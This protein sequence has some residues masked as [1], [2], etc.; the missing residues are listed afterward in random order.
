M[1]YLKIHV[2]KQFHVAN[3][4]LQQ[5]FLP[6]HLYLSSLSTLLHCLHNTTI[7]ITTQTIT[8]RDIQKQTRIDDKS[9]FSPLK[10]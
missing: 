7:I 9:A 6:N 1:N 10:L 3:D 5:L 4:V 8:T 2:L